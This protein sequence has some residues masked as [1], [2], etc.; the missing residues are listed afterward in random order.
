MTPS[1]TA[2]RQHNPYMI[3]FPSYCPRPVPLEQQTPPMTWPY[4]GRPIKAFSSP[5]LVPFVPLAQLASPSEKARVRQGSAS[6]AKAQQQVQVPT[7]PQP[8]RPR[9]AS[10]AQSL[11]QA[12][13]VSPAPPLSQSR[14]TSAARSQASTDA[15]P[16]PSRNSSGRGSIETYR[17]PS[18]SQTNG[19]SIAV[20]AAAAAAGPSRPELASSIPRSP[21]VASEEVWEKILSARQTQRERK[22]SEISRWDPSSDEVSGVVRLWKSSAATSLLGSQPSTNKRPRASSSRRDT[23][24]IKTA[25]RLASQTRTSEQP[26]VPSPQL[27]SSPA[28]FA[29]HTS[30]VKAMASALPEEPTAE[31]EST[32]HQTVDP[33][34]QS[35]PSVLDPNMS[36]SMRPGFKRKGWP[37][38][39][40]TR[41]ALKEAKAAA[42]AAGLQ[43]P[44][45]K[46]HRKSKKEKAAELDDELLGL[47]EGA[48]EVAQSSPM[49][50]SDVFDGE[51]DEGEDDQPPGEPVDP[52]VV[53]PCGLTRAE[54][55][56]K[57]EAK[58]LLGLTEV[59]VKAVQDEM[60]MRKKDA[61]GGAPIRKDGTVRKKP[62]PAKGWK[63]L[64]GDPGR[65]ESSRGDYDSDGADTSNAGDTVNGE[66]EAEIAALLP[67][68]GPKKGR[69]KAKRRKLDDE[70]DEITRYAEMSD[71]ERP[72]VD[73]ER[74]DGRAKVKTKENGAGKGRGTRPT[75]PEKALSRMAE[76][77]AGQVEAGSAIMDDE[78]GMGQEPVGQIKAPNQE[79]PRGVSETEAKVRS[80]LVEELQRQAWLT[81]VRDIPRVSKLVYPT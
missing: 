39:H 35:W 32:P 24:P 73:D 46:Y 62:G 1:S 66:A 37:S 30:A 75:K 59:D 16:G 38:D 64:R 2:G 21:L 5:P 77:L 44:K 19:H 53:Q 13:T 47:A 22:T 45:R 40:P 61:A 49:P 54:V 41:I 8:A 9:S 51:P 20:P 56:A 80:G 4:R 69:A 26:R 70:M 63:K 7:P 68:E 12:Q 11:P 72:D 27:N 28:Q 55:I 52:N 78:D 60:W 36:D 14:P 31:L 15:S 29:A 33:V 18:P 67:D 10:Q 6:K 3:P 23:P 50:I 65:P 25:D 57:I 76:E 34:D 17:S 81:I 43:V 74:D 42:I 58:D 48:G 79:D 71:D